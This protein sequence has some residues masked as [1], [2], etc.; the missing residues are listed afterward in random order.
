AFATGASSAVVF[1]RRG[2]EPAEEPVGAAQLVCRGRLERAGAD[3]PSRVDLVP[4][5]SRVV[6]PRADHLDSLPDLRN[7]HARAVP[8]NDLDDQRAV[9]PRVARREQPFQAAIEPQLDVYVAVIE[10]GLDLLDGSDRNATAALHLQ[11][12]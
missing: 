7:Q 6:D 1:G 4:A 9:D 11:P 5:V 3:P 10:L 2:L 12:R 8:G